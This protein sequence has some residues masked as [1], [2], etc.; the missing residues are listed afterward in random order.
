MNNSI[1]DQIDID[2]KHIDEFVLETE[3]GTKRTKE[4]HLTEDNIDLWMYSYI[5]EGDKLVELTSDN[6]DKYLGKTVKFRFAIF[7]ESKKGICSKCA[8]HFFHRIGIKNVGIASYNMM[9]RIKNIAMKAF[10]DP[11]VKVTT[12]RKYESRPNI[13]LYPYFLI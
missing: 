12:M 3:E 10:H 9:S 2:H 1:L 4:V 8:G 7:C 13:F 6:K 5:V 11:T